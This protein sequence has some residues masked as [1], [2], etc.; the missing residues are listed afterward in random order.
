MKPK[1]RAHLICPARL[2]NCCRIFITLFFYSFDFKFQLFIFVS[3]RLSI[4]R[5]RHI[6]GIIFR[7]ST[8]FFTFSRLLSFLGIFR[9]LSGFFDIFGIIFVGSFSFIIRLHRIR[10]FFVNFYI[11]FDMKSCPKDIILINLCF[12]NVDGCFFNIRLVLFAKTYRKL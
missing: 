2:F 12:R 9:R 3:F 5:C 6:P 10:C 7:F 1:H 11:S 8:C 4:V